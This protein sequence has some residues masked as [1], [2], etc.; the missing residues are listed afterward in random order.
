MKRVANFPVSCHQDHTLGLLPCLRPAY[1]P[2]LL[3]FGLTDFAFL[4]IVTNLISSSFL[5]FL[6]EEFAKFTYLF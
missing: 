2:Q 6:S 5:R 4:V 1:L 3:L